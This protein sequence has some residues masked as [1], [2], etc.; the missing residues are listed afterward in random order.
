M[1]HPL[2]PFVLFDNRF[3]CHCHSAI[4]LFYFIFICLASSTRPQVA[5]VSRRA[6]YFLKPHCSL[7]FFFAFTTRAHTYH[8]C[9][10]RYLLCLHFLP[11]IS[12]RPSCHFLIFFNIIFFTFLLLCCR[13]KFSL[14]LASIHK[15]N[16]KQESN[17]ILTFPFLFMRLTHLPVVLILLCRLRTHCHR[18][19]CQ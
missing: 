16:N 15:A 18:F 1:L 11:M 12:F 14:S 10:S 4:L 8:F 3:V 19:A 6:G 13:K 17:M 2:S 5:Y 9:H 7:H